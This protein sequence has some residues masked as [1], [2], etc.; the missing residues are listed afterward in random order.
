MTLLILAGVMA[1]FI[2]KA[3]LDLYSVSKGQ[4]APSHE[5]W[6]IKQDHRRARGEQPRPET[7]SGRRPFREYLGSVWADAL[8]TQAIKAHNRHLDKLQWIE[9][10]RPQRTEEWLAKQREKAER[11]RQRRQNFFAD[12]HVIVDLDELRARRARGTGAP[13]APTPNEPS[14]EGG[15]DKGQSPSEQ[16]TEQPSEADKQREH[17]RWMTAQELFD[18]ERMRAHERWMT[19]Q[20][21]RQESELPQTGGEQSHTYRWGY[22]PPNAE[23]EQRRADEAGEPRFT[24]TAWP[25]SGQ[26]RR[27]T[28]AG[29]SGKPKAESQTEDKAEDTPETIKA[30]C[31]RVADPEPETQQLDAPPLAIEA[32]ATGADGQPIEDAV[33]VEDDDTTTAGNNASTTVAEE[34]LATVTPLHRTN[35]ETG[36]HAM[37]LEGGYNGLANSLEDMAQQ[38]DGFKTFV[39]E[40]SGAAEVDD[41]DPGWVTEFRGTN[42]YIE[43]LQDRFTTLAA[44]LREKGDATRDVYNA[45]GA[46][47]KESVMAE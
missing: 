15:D 20:D 41:W 36:G 7:P 25:G 16:P 46:G 12:R 33:L 1:A 3:G 31:E 37:A 19:A 8:E 14:P 9:E 2:Q 10:E 39:D 47:T 26:R 30:T 13:D 34:Q 11:R 22:A 35:T 5:K 29:S 23:G 21:G 28:D 38:L 24:Y 17:E 32:P 40:Q 4:V 45:H 18:R 42:D 43:T 44:S 27:R 6:K